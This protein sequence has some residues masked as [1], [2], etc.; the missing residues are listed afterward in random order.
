VC[1]GHH[2]WCPCWRLQ[3]RLPQV[4]QQQQQPYDAPGR[5]STLDACN[6][7]AAL[8]LVAKPPRQA[9]AIK[10]VKVMAVKCGLWQAR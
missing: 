5:C 8:T 3:G 10:A 1:A 2:W 9:L 4:K 7:S 6:I